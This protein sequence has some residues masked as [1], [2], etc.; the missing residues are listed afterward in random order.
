M[1]P[2]GW[3]KYNDNVV[4]IREAE[5]HRKITTI[6]LV[7]NYKNR[8]PP[9]EKT[10]AFFY[11]PDEYVEDM[12]QR[13]RHK[14]SNEMRIRV[15]L[16]M[17]YGATEEEVKEI[18]SNGLPEFEVS[19][20]KETGEPIEGVNLNELFL[21]NSEST[22]GSKMKIQG[23]D[24]AVMF[25]GP[26][27]VFMELPETIMVGDQCYPR[28]IKIEET[29]KE[30]CEFQWFKAL[31]GPENERNFEF[32]WQPCGDGFTYHVTKADIGYKLRVSCD[33]NHISRKTF[34]NILQSQVAC[35][36]KR[37]DK[38][39]PTLHARSR[40]VIIDTI[41]GQFDA[42]ADRHAFTSSRLPMDG[43]RFRVVSYNILADF[44]NDSKSSLSEWYPYCRPEVLNIDYRKKL[45]IREVRGYNSD[46]ICLQEVD[47]KIFREDLN[48]LM[49]EDGLNGSMQRKG[50]M[51]EGMATFY[52]TRKFRWGIFYVYCIETHPMS[53]SVASSLIWTG[54]FTV[55]DYLNGHPSM[56]EL[57]NKIKEN[58]PLCDRVLLLP[59][60]LQVR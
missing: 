27:A 6:S 16:G 19:M 7:F 21:S 36:P 24:Y 60:S 11:S 20:V 49:M 54:G 47:T 15:K 56:L 48:L 18:E 29:T 5:D 14:I 12:T 1:A 59:T 43:D 40:N 46:I 25:N 35:I 44:Y 8:M 32:D 23:E 50:A 17:T 38:F 9:M 52:D 30:E 13:I 57:F 2:R 3:Y 26:F 45:C 39:G 34:K 33:S 41:G 28:N 51:P 42:F 4:F 53:R 37:G 58:K 22:L 55:G 10:Y 31:P